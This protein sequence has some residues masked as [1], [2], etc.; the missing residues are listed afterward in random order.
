MGSVGQI[1]VVL[2]GAPG[3]GKGTQ[4]LRLVKDLGYKHVSTGDLLRLEVSKGST[5]GKKVKSVLDSGDL[6]SDELVLDLLKANCDFGSA[7][8][9]FDGYPRNLKQAQAFDKEVIN[10]RKFSVLYFKINENELVER[11]TSRRTCSNCK[12]IYN[13][14][15]LPPKKAGICDDC[16]T[17]TLEQRSDDKE[18]VVKN[19]V[20]VYLS[21]V[22]P[23]LDFYKEKKVL[24]EIDASL[25]IDQIYKEV[26]KILELK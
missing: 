10:G 15:S 26:L 16:N 20:N 5:L 6:V 22:K 3:S 23:V 9:I 17:A 13:L 1:Q 12:R 24:K 4:A 18:D 11:L 19:R 14:K 25:E 21:T 8:F 7:K 2:I